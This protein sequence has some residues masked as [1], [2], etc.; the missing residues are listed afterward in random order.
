MQAA[1]INQYGANDAVQIGERPTPTIRPNDLLIAVKA[2]SVNPVDFKI[3]A[4]K[5][6]QIRAYEFPLTLGNDLSGVVAEVGS[7]VTKFKVG[8]EV[9]AR[10]DKDRIG[11]FAE[12]AAVSES[13]VALKPKNLTHVEAAC[14]WSR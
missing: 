7:A 5:L 3:R 4:G 1:F 2:A 11:T 14:R 10:V 13:A 9:Y 6:K 8:D 12:F